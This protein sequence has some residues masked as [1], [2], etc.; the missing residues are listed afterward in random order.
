[1]VAYLSS[2][3]LTLS[4]I[5]ACTCA[6]LLGHLLQ[7][8]QRHRRRLFWKQLVALESVDLVWALV[9]ILLPAIRLTGHEMNGSYCNIY[10]GCRNFLDFFS[11]ILEVQLAAGFAAACRH[12]VR[13]TAA[14]HWV[15][16]VACVLS[17]MLMPFQFT[18]WETTMSG[19]GDPIPLH[20][21]TDGVGCIQTG[22][23]VWD[24]TVCFCCF[25]ALAL[26]TWGAIGTLKAP[27]V[28]RRRALLCGLC[29]ILSFVLTFGFRA[30][31]D[32]LLQDNTG[33]C[34]WHGVCFVSMA[35]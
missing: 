31:Q 6:L 33:L 11:S 16:P 3:I 26:Y 30:F 19:L 14:L 8:S 15:I 24:I 1:M 29:Y 25:L 9:A 7:L 13:L 32:I 35:Q 4:G 23:P 17:L 20:I 5:S 28:V 2:I 34:M 22:Q 12:Y 21:I 18:H 27:V 10:L